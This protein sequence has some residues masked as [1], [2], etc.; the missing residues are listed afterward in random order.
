M[1][2]LATTPPQHPAKLPQGAGMW[3][4]HLRPA[5]RLKASATSSRQSSRKKVEESDTE[6]RKLMLPFPSMTLMNQQCWL[7]R[8]DGDEERIN[9]KT[10]VTDQ[11]EKTLIRHAERTRTPA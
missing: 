9:N 6:G 7:M 2:D 5:H 3:K 11:R 10:A 1:T 4:A 8:Q